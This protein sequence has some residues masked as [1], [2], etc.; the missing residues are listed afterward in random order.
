MKKITDGELFSPEEFSGILEVERRKI[1][2]AKKERR[3][4]SKTFSYLFENRETVL[5]QMNEMVLIENIHDDKEKKHI[6]DT[7]NELIPDDLEFSVSMFIEISDEKKLLQEMPRLSGI[8][9]NVYLVFGDYEVKG[10]PEEGRSTDTLEST[11]QY[12]RF[13]FDGK[14][15]EQFKKAKNAFIVTRH[16]IYK[17]SAEITEPL[18]AQLKSEL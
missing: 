18:L 14:T 5:N 8:E 16:P 13:K 3:I 7:Y 4:T 12:L 17:E 1:I 9:N 10:A 15:A 11:L 6:L 2:K